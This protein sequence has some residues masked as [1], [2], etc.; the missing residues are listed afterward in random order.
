[1]SKNAIKIKN[2][3]SDLEIYSENSFIERY[4]NLYKNLENIK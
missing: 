2:I 4:D 3:N 1:M